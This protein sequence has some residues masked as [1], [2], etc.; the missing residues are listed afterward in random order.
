MLDALTTGTSLIFDGYSTP[1]IE[2]G[3]SLEIVLQNLGDPLG[4]AV[5]GDTV[6]LFYSGGGIELK[7]GR[8]I[9]I[10]SDFAEKSRESALQ[11]RVEAKQR[12]KGLVNYH[13]SWVS[14]EEA[15]RLEAHAQRVKA[16]QQHRRP[17]SISRSGTASAPGRRVLVIQPAQYVQTQAE[18]ALQRLSWT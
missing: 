11:Q 1:Q 14:P 6:I 17:V 5:T 10:E 9:R 13:G 18:K 16:S 7:D 8:V 12:A 4:Q 2:I 3:D 15:K